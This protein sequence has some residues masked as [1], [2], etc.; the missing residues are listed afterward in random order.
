MTT[1]EINAKLEK[2]I[3]ELNKVK[4]YTTK[5]ANKLIEN[6]LDI[7]KTNWAEDEKENN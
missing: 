4:A 1:K 5:L 7:P 6:K 2:L 3:T